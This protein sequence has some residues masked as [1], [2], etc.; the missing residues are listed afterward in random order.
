MTLY[1]SPGARSSGAGWAMTLGT[2]TAAPTER[3]AGARLCAVWDPLLQGRRQLILGVAARQRQ[4]QDSA[5]PPTQ[6]STVQEGEPPAK[7]TVGAS[8]ELS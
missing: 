1:T 7:S 2:G 8:V 3:G 6:G 5:S 4:Q